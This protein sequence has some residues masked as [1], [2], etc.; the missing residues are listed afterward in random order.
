MTDPVALAET[1]FTQAKTAAKAQHDAYTLMV[2]SQKG[3]LDGMKSMGYPFEAASAQFGKM[4]DFHGQQYAA[5]V[6]H[7]DQMFAEWQSMIAKA[8][9]KPKK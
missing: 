2:N 5:A 7:M 6:K 9:G 8:N 1:F 3:M 4:I